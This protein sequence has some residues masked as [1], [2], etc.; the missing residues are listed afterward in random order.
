MERAIDVM[1]VEVLTNLFRDN[2]PQPPNRQPPNPPPDPGA[3]NGDSGFES[4]A[5]GQRS[6][7]LDRDDGIH[8]D[9][10]TGTKPFT[11]FLFFF[12]FLNFI[13][14]SSDFQFFAT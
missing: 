14:S 6:D 9:A 10:E 12:F 8:E 1:L 4:T 11:F 5:P 3:G 2:P 7:A 13:F